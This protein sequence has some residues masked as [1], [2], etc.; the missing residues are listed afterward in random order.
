MYHDT[1]LPA[2]NNCTATMNTWACICSASGILG[3]IMGDTSIHVFLKFVFDFIFLILYSQYI[4]F[5]IKNYENLENLP[6]L[7]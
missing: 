2:M 4:T 7:H 5:L 1:K 3:N 6:W